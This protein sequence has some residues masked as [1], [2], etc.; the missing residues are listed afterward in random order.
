[1]SCI[2]TCFTKTRAPQ[3]KILKDS[4]ILSN[5]LNLGDIPYTDSVTLRAMEGALMDN[6]ISIHYKLEETKENIKYTLQ[7]GPSERVKENLGRRA[8]L[9]ERKR[10][11]EARLARVQAKLKEIETK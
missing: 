3:P 9:T 8:V 6:L 2:W 10:I 7:K 5:P 11:F 4:R 1:M